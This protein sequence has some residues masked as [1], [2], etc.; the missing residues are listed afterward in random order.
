VTA[1]FM[2]Q[3]FVIVWTETRCR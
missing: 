2:Q 1:V 3:Y